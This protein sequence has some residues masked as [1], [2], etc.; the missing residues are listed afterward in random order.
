MAAAGKGGGGGGGGGWSTG[1]EGNDEQMEV[2]TFLLPLLSQCFQGA[3]SV[4]VRRKKIVHVGSRTH[5]LVGDTL[6]TRPKRE[7]WRV[8][9]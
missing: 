1:C 7:S 2:W 6:S 4:G 9:F 3:P 8:T 5:G